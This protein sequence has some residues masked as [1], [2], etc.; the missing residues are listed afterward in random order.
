MRLSFRKMNPKELE[1]T[2]RLFLGRC[3][4]APV[5]YLITSE[6]HLLVKDGSRW[7]NVGIADLVWFFMGF[8]N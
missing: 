1:L 6:C 4:T 3:D 8:I 5:D 7:I 2:L